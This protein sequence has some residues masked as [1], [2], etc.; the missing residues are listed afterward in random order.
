MA[1][2]ETGKFSSGKGLF[3]QAGSELY[4]RFGDKKSIPHQPM[5][6]LEEVRKAVEKSLLIQN[7]DIEVQYDKENRI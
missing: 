3:V 7:A 1:K 5:P 4:G 6:I 2:F